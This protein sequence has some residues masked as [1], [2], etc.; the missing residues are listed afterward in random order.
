MLQSKEE[1]VEAEFRSYKEA[2]PDWLT[3]LQKGQ[4]V[5][6]YNFRLAALSGTVL[7]PPTPN[8]VLFYTVL[9]CFFLFSYYFLVG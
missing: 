5:A 1:E 7:F 4:V 6:S 9:T 2:N 8:L 3:N